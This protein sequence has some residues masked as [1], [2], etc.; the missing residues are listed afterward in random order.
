MKDIITYFRWVISGYHGTG[1]LD[2]WSQKEIVTRLPQL[3][4]RL[5]R[6]EAVA[7]AADEVNQK[8][9]LTKKLVGALAALEGEKG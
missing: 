1:E 3:L 6:L 8:G 4:D 9:E 5:E 2:T 7:D